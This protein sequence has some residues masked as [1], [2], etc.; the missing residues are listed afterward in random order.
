MQDLDAVFDELVRRLSTHEADFR[1]SDNT[2]DAN[3]PWS[4]KDEGA[5]D[6]GSYLLLG[7]PTETYPDGQ[8]CFSF[9]QVDG[10]L[11]DE[12]DGLTARGHELYEERGLLR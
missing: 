5:S 4:R 6:P 12:L 11:F 1:T 8:T 9:T 7:A 3:A 2:T 10:A